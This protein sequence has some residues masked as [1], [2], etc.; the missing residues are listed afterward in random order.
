MGIGNFFKFLFNL[1]FKPEGRIEHDIEEKNKATK[2]LSKEEE[3]QKYIDDKEIQY[4]FKE[5]REVEITEKL[6]N[7]LYKLSD[8][9]IQHII[10]QMLKEENM[11]RKNLEIFPNKN[12]YDRE[13]LTSENIKL[14]SNLLK[15]L[16]NIY[17]HF[18]REDNKH[19]MKL[20]KE[21]HVLYKQ[22][23]KCEEHKLEDEKE[24]H[25]LE[26]EED[27]NIKK[28][29]KLEKDEESK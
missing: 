24:I 4:G 6:L 29:E 27:E 26:Q 22:E 16:K 7:K 19:A 12:S 9:S 23:F 13:T 17:N 15:N 20:I 2:E 25:K 5:E 21:I 11:I 28:I 10:T 18:K 1:F 3:L 8:S 14:I